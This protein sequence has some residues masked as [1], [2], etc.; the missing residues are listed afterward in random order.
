MPKVAL[1]DTIR[2][3]EKLLRAAEARLGESPVL[4]K[5]I[6]ALRADFESLRQLDSLRVRL[7]AERQEATQKLHAVRERGK[8]DAISLRAMLVSEL[9][10]HN[11]GLVEFDIRPR[12]PR[13]RR[14]KADAGSPSGDEPREV[15]SA[16]TGE[17]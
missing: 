7:A 3:W 15:L 6:Q 10:P 13:S 11:E 9:G 4:A 16:P 2:E 5:H 14:K 12:R 8:T 17:I 1:A